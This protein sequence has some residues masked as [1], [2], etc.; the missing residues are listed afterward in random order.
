MKFEIFKK[1]YISWNNLL[2]GDIS[3]HERG[4]DIPSLFHCFQVKMI[5][6][7]TA[8]GLV[9]IFLLHLCQW[10]ISS[11]GMIL[12]VLMIL[13]VLVVVVLIVMTASARKA[14]ISLS[15]LAARVCHW[16]HGHYG[17]SSDRGIGYLM[18][19]RYVCMCI[20]YSVLVLVLF[21]RRR[22]KPIIL[23]IKDVMRCG[24]GMRLM[25]RCNR[26]R[27]HCSGLSIL[28]RGCLIRMRLDND[29]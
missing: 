10:N 13:E 8:I 28:R 6:L 19:C 15:S 3:N 1:K 23:S 25:G 17:V 26:T 5:P 24:Y 22:L 2:V 12:M 16:I 7:V 20:W 29:V 18:I 21:P 27:E 9:V 11:I 14:R 4:S